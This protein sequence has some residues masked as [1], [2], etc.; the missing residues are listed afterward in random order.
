[1]KKIF[2]ISGLMACSV[3]GMN[4]SHQVQKANAQLNFKLK[5]FPSVE[6]KD[7]NALGN[8]C[9]MYMNVS[10]SVHVMDNVSFSDARQYACHHN[11][12]ESNIFI[13]Y[14]NEFMRGLYNL[15][16]R[17]KDA[18]ARIESDAHLMNFILTGQSRAHTPQEL[19]K[20]KESFKRVV[21]E[22]AAKS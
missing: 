17:H 8:C 6:I 4:H 3:F 14:S 7:S 11:T 13:R 10:P 18:V 21:R 19:Q 15:S 16:L 9:I 1:M 5:F 2:L 12:D 22:Y 20:I